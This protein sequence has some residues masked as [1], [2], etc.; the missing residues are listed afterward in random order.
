MVRK[1][2][3][4]LVGVA[5]L[6]VALGVF[7]LLRPGLVDAQ[8]PSASRTIMPATVAPGGEV[9]VTIDLSGSG[10]TDRLVNEVLPEGFTYKQNSTTPSGIRVSPEFQ[11]NNTDVQ[12][13]FF[14]ITTS[15]IT[16]F[17]YTV[18]ASSQAD[19]YMF[20]GEFRYVDQSDEPLT[21]DD[22]RRR[23]CGNGGGWNDARVAGGDA[24][25]G[26]RFKDDRSGDGCSR[27]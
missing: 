17:S 22:G 23:H 24:R 19:D 6:S 20:S 10:F 5:V 1:A 4:L 7:G 12:E 27:R 9:V 13:V 11:T 14:T 2:L 25:G 26:R 8:T 15:S 3:A 18:I 21:L 16:Q